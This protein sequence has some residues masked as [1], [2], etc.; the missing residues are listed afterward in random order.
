MIT[1][2]LLAA[3][4]LMLF[5]A[6]GPVLARSQWPN[7]APRA[8]I[9]LWQAIGL[10]GA[11]AA[12]GAGLAVTV[13]PL[14]GGLLGGAMQLVRQA[15]AGHPLAGLGIDGSL[16]LTLA[17]DVG[18]VLLIGLIVAAI[19][20]AR[21]RA[22][23]RRVLDLVGRRS[24]R[25]PGALLLDD[26]RVAAYCLPGVRPRIVLSAGALEILD[27]EGLGAVLA[28]ERGHARER[29]GIVLLPFAAMDSLLHFIPYARHARPAVAG[30]LEMAADDFA[31]RR[32]ARHTLAEALV[33][34]ASAG[35]APSCALAA[36][37]TAVVVRVQRLLDPPTSSSVTASAAIALATC[38]VALPVAVILAA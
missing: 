32:I 14:H 23:H 1:A 12:I 8:A 10:A 17:T 38:I 21:T 9:V 20:T 3:L 6:A 28:H 18:A 35:A 7:R 37:S 4:A 31:T 13:A 36:A 15:R 30:L 5:G 19:R 27:N 24:E 2:A 26:A 25:A 34:M 16:G 33:A 29:H 22:V 11:L